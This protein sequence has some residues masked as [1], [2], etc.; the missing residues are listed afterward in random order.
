MIQIK[1]KIHLKE[2]TTFKIGGVAD[3]F[4]AV[5]TVEDLKEALN[6]SREENLKV[7]VLGGGSNMLISDSGFRGLVVYMQI[8]GLQI[9]SEDQSSIK[10]R[11]A[12]GENWDTVV[13]TAVQN[14]WWGIEN[15]SHIPGSAGAF[16]VQNVGAYGQDASQVVESVQAISVSTGQQH[17]FT[18]A[19]CQFGYRSSIF[20]RLHKGEYVITH[21]TLFLSKA[22]KPNL[23]YKDLAA[24]LL[25]PLS[26]QQPGLADIRKAVISIR[27]KKFPYPKDATNGSAGSFFKNVLLDKNQFERLSTSIKNNFDDSVQQRWQ[28]LSIRESAEGIKVSSAFLLD[29]CGFKGAQVGGARVNQNQPLVLMNTGKATANEVL[30]LAGKIRKE[31]FSKTAVSLEPE[32][33]FIGFSEGEL[34]QYLKIN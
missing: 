12:S 24:A 4:A 28:A 21:T 30:E 10:I 31:V 20:N 32:P 15:L 17:S 19:E 9:I 3:Y 6:F 29:I 13:E 22:A 33:E 2:F 18:A 11:I 5:H 25:S 8:Q 34:D 23:S 16:A 7:L 14:G 27:D 26:P 1:Q